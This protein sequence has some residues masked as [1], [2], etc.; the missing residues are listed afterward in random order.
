MPAS[1]LKARV[2]NANPITNTTP[3]AIMMSAVGTRRAVRRT[4]A[5]AYSPSFSAKAAIS[6][7]PVSAALPWRPSLMIRRGA[8]P[9]PTGA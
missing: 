1:V 6:A 9:N 4:H 8:V 2:T 5:A 3:V 7:P